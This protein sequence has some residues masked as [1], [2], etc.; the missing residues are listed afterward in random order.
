[1]AAQPGRGRAVIYRRQN[2]IPFPSHLLP[3]AN[4]NQTTLLR[5]PHVCFEAR[6]WLDQFC[7]LLTNLKHVHVLPFQQLQPS[8]SKRD[9]IDILHF[10]SGKGSNVWKPATCFCL[11][12]FPKVLTYFR[13]V[14]SKIPRRSRSI[15]LT[16]QNRV[17]RRMRDSGAQL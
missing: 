4:D 1:M 17:Y 8:P 7:P 2:E 10:S 3:A 9:P 16:Y 6:D 13:F 12:F 5:T 14:Y 15:N 11:V